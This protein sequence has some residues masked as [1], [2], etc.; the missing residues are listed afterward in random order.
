VKKVAGAILAIVLLTLIFAALP[1]ITAKP[2]EQKVP[3]SVSFEITSSTIVERWI[4]GGNISHR[5]LDQEWSV[6]LTVGDSSTPIV[7][8][9]IVV[10]NTDYRYTKQ[11]GVDQI[12]NDKYIFSFP[13]DEGGFEGHSHTMLTNWNSVDRTYDVAVH[14]LLHGTGEFEGQTLN[15]W[16]NGPGVIPLWEGYLL[17]P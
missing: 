9:A 17:K 11:G 6:E 13:T 8:T 16:Q 14:V 2:E 3:V 10:R 15:A 4:T 5:L 12:V 7:G 1:S